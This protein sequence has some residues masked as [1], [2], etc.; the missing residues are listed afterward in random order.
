MTTGTHTKGLE[1]WD[2]PVELRLQIYR[3][4]IPTILGTGL[5]LSHLYV[6]TGPSQADFE[7]RFSET[8]RR[9][10]FD[11][12]DDVACEVFTYRQL[13]LSCRLIHREIPLVFPR[14]L[15][16]RIEL[17]GPLF[18]SGFVDSPARLPPLPWTRCTELV[19][20]FK[21]IGTFD[22]CGNARRGLEKLIMGI[23]NKAP[24][25]HAPRLILRMSGSTELRKRFFLPSCVMW[26]RSVWDFSHCLINFIILEAR[27]AASGSDHHSL[28]KG[29]EFFR[30][31]T[32]R[33]AA[34]MVLDHP[35]LQTL[36]KH[37]SLAHWYMA[38][39]DIIKMLRSE[40]EEVDFAV[41]CRLQSLVDVLDMEYQM[42]ALAAA[43]MR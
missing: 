1:L 12:T 25:D 11:F 7:G 42:Q 24:V 19:I 31:Y 35:A 28:R 20:D 30:D 16:F 6:T 17:S 41:S 29:L 15:N 8:R 10:D 4:T 39:S 33:A 23:S 37:T 38:L 32:C 13:S 26:D 27:F 3:Y 18:F 21:N 34:T 5:I 14:T 9:F 2:L 36:S 22:C 40:A 43:A